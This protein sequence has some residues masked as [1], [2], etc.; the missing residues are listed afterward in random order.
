MSS[1]LGRKYHFREL[2]QLSKGAPRRPFTPA[3]DFAVE[4]WALVDLF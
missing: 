1:T 4:Q 3:G 2:L